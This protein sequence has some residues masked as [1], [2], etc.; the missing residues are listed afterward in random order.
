MWLTQTKEIFTLC[1]TT[2][3]MSVHTQCLNLVFMC[4]QKV[5]DKQVAS[6]CFSKL[7]S[8]SSATCC[9][10]ILHVRESRGGAFKHY[11]MGTWAA[12]AFRSQANKLLIYIYAFKCDMSRLCTQS[13]LI[14]TVEESIRQDLQCTATALNKQKIF[15]W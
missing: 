13:Q 14:F 1:S 2:W 11:S 12:T 7:D 8:S 4:L 6:K 10:V 9:P 15:S 5:G 3:N